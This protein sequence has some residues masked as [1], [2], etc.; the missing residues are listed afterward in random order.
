MPG[1]HIDKLVKEAAEKLNY[2][3]L[4]TDQRKTATKEELA[5]DDL[6]KNAKV[7]TDVFNS[8]ESSTTLTAEEKQEVFQKLGKEVTTHQVSITS[9]SSKNTLMRENSPGTRF[10]SSYMDQY[11][12]DY[13]NSVHETAKLEASKIKL[14]SSISGKQINGGPYGNIPDAPKEDVDKLHEAYG[15][16]SKKVLQASEENL[17]KLTPQAKAFMQSVL[18]PVAHDPVATNLVSANTLLLRGASPMMSV[19]GAKLRGTDSTRDVGNLLMGSGVVV[20]TYA[21]SLSKDST[22]KLHTDKLQNVT[23]NTLRTDDALKQT[24]SAY[25]ALA[26]G[27][28]AIN[29][30]SKDLQAKT[31]LK[32]FDDRV[33]QL[34][35][36]K[37]QLQQNPSALDK[38]KCFFKHG[39]KGV[40]GEIDKIDKKIEVT[41]I[42]KESV[43]KGNSMEDLQKKLD[44]MKVDRAEFLL[45]METAKG[46]VVSNNAA[47]SVNMSSGF[48]EGQVDKAMSTHERAKPEAE[49]LSAQ[50]KQQEKVMSVREKLGPKAPQ[51]GQG[52]KQGVSKV[53]VTK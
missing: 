5:S 12:K 35:D 39:M 52:E 16:L 7:G 34:N 41:N 11:A 31:A 26:G 47:K 9:P 42:A 19:D 20:Q 3:P 17:S 27:E 30:F 50:I 36:K 48:S 14:P 43:E 49:N 38:I 21:N 44:G 22:E 46:V 23:A 6:K 1:D 32:P 29:K 4:T 53:S 10:I 24:G 8:I 33:Q 13:F 15:Q 28:D 25:K 40:Q 45:A 18:E 2:V 51:Q 37:T